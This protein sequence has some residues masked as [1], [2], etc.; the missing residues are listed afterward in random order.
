MRVKIVAVFAKLIFLRDFT[1]RTPTFDHS[2][3]AFTQTAHH[4]FLDQSTLIYK[5]GVGSPASETDIPIATLVDSSLYRFAPAR[6]FGIYALAA[7]VN[8]LR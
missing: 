8:R 1:E 6:S 3:S 4:P 5:M 2:L 7:S